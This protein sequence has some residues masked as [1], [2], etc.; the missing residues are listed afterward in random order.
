MKVIQTVMRVSKCMTELS[1]LGEL[2][3]FEGDTHSRLCVSTLFKKVVRG[4]G[5]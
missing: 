4:Q 2:P 1:F 3:S 5:K